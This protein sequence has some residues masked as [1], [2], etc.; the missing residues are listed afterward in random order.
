MTDI[1]IKHTGSYTAQELRKFVEGIAENK[2]ATQHDKLDALLALSR[3]THTYTILMN[4]RLK[5]VE[6]IVEEVTKHPFHLMSPKTI[7]LMI[8][9][10]TALSLVYIQESRTFLLG[11]IGITLP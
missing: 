7:F 5:V 2:N 6:D 3:D 4:G 11:L 9:T 8:V 1:E 10:F